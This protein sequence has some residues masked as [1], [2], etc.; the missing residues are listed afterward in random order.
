M[1]F[2]FGH[3]MMILISTVLVNN[4]VLFKTLKLCPFMGVSTKLDASIG[5]A[6]AMGFVL[7]IGSMT[8]WG[9]NYY[10]LEP[11]HLEYLRTLSFIVIIAG[12]VQFTE[13]LIE[14]NFPPLHQALGVLLP[15]IITNC[16]VLGIPLF[17]AQTSH[18]LVESILYGMGGAIGFFLVLVLFASLRERLEAAD[19]PISLKGSAITLVTAA[20][21]S[22]AFMGFSS[23]DKY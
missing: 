18:S 5:M 16:V 8:S 7:S 10:L 17:N 21:M 15:L 19:V 9:I 4:I 22:L 12:V 6:G 1:H 2:D 11:N 13:M 14:K 20:L 3:Y 23:L